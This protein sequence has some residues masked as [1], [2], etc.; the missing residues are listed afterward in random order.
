MVPSLP[1]HSTATYSTPN[2]RHTVQRKKT[3][4]YLC[5]D[6]LCR[7]VSVVA[8]VDRRRD[9]PPLPLGRAADGG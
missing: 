4:T 1:Y 8:P 2:I 5:R 6:L 9:T 7:A 3:Y